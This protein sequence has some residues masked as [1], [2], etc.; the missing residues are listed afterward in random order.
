VVNGFP[1][2]LAYTKPLNRHNIS[3]TQI[4]MRHNFS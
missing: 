4:V 1:T 3:P 2:L